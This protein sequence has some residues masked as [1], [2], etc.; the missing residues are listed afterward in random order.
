MKC[1]A[2]DEQGFNFRHFN[3][4]VYKVDKFIKMSTIFSYS[5]II[6]EIPKRSVN[7]S[8]I[9]LAGFKELVRSMLK[10]GGVTSFVF[11]SSRSGKTT[12][13]VNHMIPIFEE[14][15]C[16]IAFLPNHPAEIYRP[17]LVDKNVAILPELRTDVICDIVN[18]QRNQMSLPSYEDLAKS[19]RPRWTFVLDDVTSDI[20]K[21]NNEVSRCYTTYRNIGISTITAIQYVVMAKK[22]SRANVNLSLYFKLNTPEA[23]IAVIKDHLPNLFVTPPGSKKLTVEEK[24]DAYAALTEKYIIISDNLNGEYHIL[25]RD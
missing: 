6:N 19:E 2:F 16:V 13:L 15:S 3:L 5:D 25:P 24:A 20:F 11:G 17:L 12:F 14:S 7:A 1:T 21:T 10:G 18:F 8:L 4:P 22:E 23:R 9:T